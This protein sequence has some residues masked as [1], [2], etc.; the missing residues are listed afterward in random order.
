MSTTT[1]TIVQ[2]NNNKLSGFPLSDPTVKGVIMS[3]APMK[4][5]FHDWLETSRHTLSPSQLVQFMLPVVEGLVLLD[6]MGLSLFYHS[7]H[8][9]GIL[10]R[11]GNDED[12]SDYKDHQDGSRPQEYAVVFDNSV[13]AM[14]PTNS[15]TQRA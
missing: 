11:D 3:L 7:I 4:G 12:S 2:H 9:I 1:A 14:I 8:N 6:N 5:T 10:Q 13:L 15:R